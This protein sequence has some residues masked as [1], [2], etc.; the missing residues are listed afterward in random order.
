MTLRATAVSRKHAAASGS[1]QLDAQGRHIR[2]KLLVTDQGEDILVD[3]EKPA[4]LRHG[5]C[6]MLE[7][8]RAIAVHAAVEE[9]LEVRARD[10]EHHARL[11]WHIGNRHLEA[12][13]ETHRILIRPDHVIASMLEQQG[14]TVTLVNEPFSPEPGAYSHV[15]AS[16][17]VGTYSY[18]P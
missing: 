16:E 13:I 18:A 3:L 2:R 9:L 17:P 11:A 7:D 6:L 12:Q 15:H 14:A 4:H 8:G 1:V 5:D 10:I